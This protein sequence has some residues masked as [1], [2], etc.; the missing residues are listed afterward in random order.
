ML[1]KSRVEKFPGELLMPSKAGRIGLIVGPMFSGKT[2]ELFRRLKRYVIAGKSVI[3]LS[4][5]E[6]NDGACTTHSGES[7]EGVT[8]KMVTEAEAL[9]P[10]PTFLRDAIWNYDVVGI[11]E[12]QFFGTVLVDVLDHVALFGKVVVIAGLSADHKRMPWAVVS[13]L[14][15]RADTVDKLTAVC[16]GCGEE[17]CWTRKLHPKRSEDLKDFGG[18]DKYEACCRPCYEKRKW[19]EKK[20]NSA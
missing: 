4:R 11:D 1:S 20:I 10:S 6:R 3:F 13:L 14:H 9:D 18:K 17:A 15:S 8:K 19:K 2:T 7:I 12:C 16:V 5:D